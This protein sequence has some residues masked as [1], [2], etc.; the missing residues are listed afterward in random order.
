MELNNYVD[1]HNQRENKQMEN[2]LTYKSQILEILNNIEK[3]YQITIFYASETGS[4]G[5]GIDVED[6]DFDITGFFA[7]ID[8][9]EYFK[10]IRKYENTI[11]ITQDSVKINNKNY[12]IDIE[13]WDVKEWFRSKV[14][15]NLTGCDYWFESKLVYKDLY[16]DIVNEIKKYV[17]PPSLLYWGKAKS[18][19]VYAVKDIK[20]KG[21]CYIKTLMN[22]LTSLIQFFH[23]QVFLTFPIY[24]ILSEIGFLIQEKN[25]ILNKGDF[26]EEEFNILCDSFKLYLELYEEKKKMR[27]GMKQNV[28]DLLND[29]IRLLES[30]Y[31]THKKKYELQI[32][33]KEG[34][35]QDLFDDILKRNKTR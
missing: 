20:S 11:S 9:L 34:V 32:L 33:L 21:G 16:P 13:L 19:M 28:P 30:K 26:N 35:A 31:N 4:R 22:I 2:F 15:K 27:K 17:I 3:E 1:K 25:D 12:E 24:N 23:Y 8:E 18:G 14:T 29:L 10:I 7:P 5:L 6:L